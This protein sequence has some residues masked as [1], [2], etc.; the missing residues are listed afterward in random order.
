MLISGETLGEF[1]NH[2]QARWRYNHRLLHKGGYENKSIRNPTVVMSGTEG[3]MRKGR[4]LPLGKAWITQGQ[5]GIG[6]CI[7]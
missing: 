6:L 1:S 5:R 2:V 3:T 7:E 4:N